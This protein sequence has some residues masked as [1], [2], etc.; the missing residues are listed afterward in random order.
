MFCV[1]DG[2]M[3]LVLVLL[4]VLVLVVLL[5]LVAFAIQCSKTV[6]KEVA[7]GLQVVVAGEEW[8]V[9]AEGE[10]GQHLG[11]ARLLFLVDVEPGRVSLT[12]ARKPPSSSS[13]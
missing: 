3:V 10:E 1:V 11:E 12:A 8:Q 2:G 5:L 7:L 6:S 9:E 4:L 13:S